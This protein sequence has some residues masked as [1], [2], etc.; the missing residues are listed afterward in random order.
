MFSKISKRLSKSEMM[1]KIEED[2]EKNKA[3]KELVWRRNQNEDKY[4]ELNELLQCSSYSFSSMDRDI[5]TKEVADF[6]SQTGMEIMSFESSNRSGKKSVCIWDFDDCLVRM[7]EFFKSKNYKLVDSCY[8]IES[9]AKEIERNHFFE[10]QLSKF[11]HVNV[12]DLERVD[13]FLD[14]STFNFAK[15]DLSKDSKNE[16]SFRKERCYRLRRIADIYNSQPLSKLLR[17]KDLEFL[18]RNLEAIDKESNY[19]NSKVK[20]FIQEISSHGAVMVVISNKPLLRILSMMYLFGFN[21]LISADKVYSFEKSSPR[22]CIEEIK[23]RFGSS[24]FFTILSYDRQLEKCASSCRISYKRI[25]DRHDLED[26]RMAL[27]RQL[28]K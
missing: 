1:A 16:S 7:E 18:R 26:F 28:K 25:K 8:E 14:L 4:S 11:H 9:L 19:W 12:N 6:Q 22:Y 20:R 23:Q 5:L 15:D 24:S 13:D 17:S 2:R 27:E 10:A 21:N 3:N